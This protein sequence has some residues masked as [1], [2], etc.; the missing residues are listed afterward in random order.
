MAAGASPAAALA[1]LLILLGTA[2]LVAEAWVLPRAQL[3]KPLLVG[4]TR[5]AAAGSRSRRGAGALQ[6]SLLSDPAFI[7]HAAAQLQHG[8][9]AASWLFLADADLSTLKDTL[10]DASELLKSM[11]KFDDFKDSIPKL[12]D[13][14][15]LPSQLQDALKV[16]ERFVWEGLNGWVGM[17]RWL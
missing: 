9:G 13:A 5:A 3:H 15:A 17:R 7:E 14:P 11:P 10:P 16:R 8:P 12:P 2:C 6:A 1:L 4:T